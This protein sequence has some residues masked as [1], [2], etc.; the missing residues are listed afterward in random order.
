M[1][2]VWAILLSAGESS[3]M[4]RLK[5][6]LPWRNTTLIEYQ[7]RSLL[8]AGVQQVVVVLGH[9]ADRLKPIVDAVEGASWTLN[10]DY[11][12]GKTT[13]LKT[14]VA[15]LA[16]QQLSDVLLLNVDQP[17]SADTVRTLLERHQ[18]SSF[19][20]TIPTHGGKGGHPILI[21]ADL[22]PELAE[23]EEESQ[24]LKAVVRRHAEATERFEVDDPTV[25]LDLNTPEQYQKA[26]ESGL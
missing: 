2:G 11:L 3:R 5:A 19:R 22:L 9:D 13:S 1:P 17:R 23:I 21:A 24:G 7:L 6:L 14:G 12:Q 18:A 16:G 10:H 8:D 26:L 25:L 4:G 20:I 15:A